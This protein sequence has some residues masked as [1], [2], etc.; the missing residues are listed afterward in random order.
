[1]SGCEFWSQAGPRVINRPGCPHAGTP[2][3]GHH[4]LDPLASSVPQ[5]TVQDILRPHL[6]H[7]PLVL[8]D[9][10]NILNMCSCYFYFCKIQG[11]IH[12]LNIIRLMQ[13]KHVFMTYQTMHLKRICLLLVWRRGSIL[14][15]ILRVELSDCL[16][17]P[18]QSPWF[19]HFAFQASLRCCADLDNYNHS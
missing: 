15:S 1:M 13:Y 8:T 11:C 3:F 5:I 4:Y 6:R 12:V 14:A 9:L 16:Q 2:Y 19:S 17:Q 10:S 7:N 18:D